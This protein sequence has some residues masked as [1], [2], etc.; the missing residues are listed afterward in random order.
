MYKSANLNVFQKEAGELGVFVVCMRAVRMMVMVGLVVMIMV[1][2][3][4]CRS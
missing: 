3:M 4:G 2:V 1:M